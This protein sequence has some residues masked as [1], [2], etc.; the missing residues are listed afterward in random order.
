MIRNKPVWYIKTTKENYAIN[1]AVSLSVALLFDMIAFIKTKSLF[2]VIGLP[3]PIFYLSFRA[4]EYFLTGKHIW[5]IWEVDEGDVAA[6]GAVSEV[7]LL[8]V[9]F[10]YLIFKIPQL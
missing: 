2:V 9:A 1:L 8:L 6:M 10:W 3:T 4:I 7:I 5:K